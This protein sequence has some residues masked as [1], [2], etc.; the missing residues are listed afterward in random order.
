M[1]LIGIILVHKYEYM[2]VDEAEP[3]MWLWTLAFI[4][5]VSREEKA[6]FVSIQNDACHGVFSGGP[7]VLVDF[8]TSD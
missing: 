7:E 5:F 6:E 4:I 3:W 1:I 8:S 2:M